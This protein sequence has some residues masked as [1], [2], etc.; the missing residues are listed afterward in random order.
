MT[1]LVSAL[2][3]ETIDNMAL[4][5]ALQEARRTSV[6]G[7]GDV[8]AGRAAAQ[9]CSICHGADGNVTAADTPTLAGQDALMR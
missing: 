4:Y 3:D 8:D 7:S 5:Y 9:A 2:D 1:S 6:G